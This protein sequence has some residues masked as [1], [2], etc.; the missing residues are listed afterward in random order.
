MVKRSAMTMIEL[1]F[2]I[3]LIA[4]VVAAVPQM[5]Q[6]NDKTLEGNLVQ[7]ELFVA[8]KTASELLTQPWDANATDN[9]TTRAYN[10]VLDTNS[11]N[12]G[13]NRVTDA[14][15]NPLPFR[16]G[17]IRQ[18]N[19]RRFHNT[20]T[21][22]ASAQIP[23][24]SNAPALPANTTL[25]V[26]SGYS[27]ETDTTVFSTAPT[28]SNAAPTNIKMANI[29]VTDTI[30]NSRTVTLRLYMANIGEVAYAHRRF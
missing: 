8:A 14:A 2:A 27:G 24:S 11:P 7:E 12:A 19:H 13:F 1:I 5:M 15:G 22:P 30:D 6:R 23:S 20:T 4:L 10:K 21:L 3:V 26:T 25:T 17:H 28:T 16:Q 9:S 29:T 18:D